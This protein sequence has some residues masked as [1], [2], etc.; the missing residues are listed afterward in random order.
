MSSCETKTNLVIF[1]TGSMKSPFFAPIKTK[2][3]GSFKFWELDFFPKV[4]GYEKLNFR[5]ITQLMVHKLTAEKSY[6]A[7]S[8]HLIAL[9]NVKLCITQSNRVDYLDIDTETRNIQVFRSL[10]ISRFC[11]F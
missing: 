1:S 10:A 3:L 6:F 4:K 9:F 7:V 8:L 5:R 2:F 11:H